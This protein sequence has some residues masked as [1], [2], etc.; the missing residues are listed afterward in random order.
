MKISL[1][2][3]ADILETH[4][5]DWGKDIF[6]DLIAPDD[7]KFAIGGRWCEISAGEDQSIHI[8]S[9]EGEPDIE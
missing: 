1:S 8:S 6:T 3:L 5:G 4:F 2:L 7:L 9:W